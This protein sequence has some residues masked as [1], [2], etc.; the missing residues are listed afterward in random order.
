[1]KSEVERIKQARRGRIRQVRSPTLSSKANSK[2][3]FE[4]STLCKN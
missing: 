3:V 1:M 2:T 4:V